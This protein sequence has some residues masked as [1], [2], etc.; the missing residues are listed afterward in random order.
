ME[1]IV[2]E[3]ERN[4][5]ERA[6]NE[7][8]PS[9]ADQTHLGASQSLFEA[10]CGCTAVAL[11]A[12][13]EAQRCLYMN[14]AAERMTGFSYAQV[15]GRSL[16]GSADQTDSES[17]PL[18]FKAGSIKQAL[19]QESPQQGR[20]CFVHQDGHSFPVEYS[21]SPLHTPDCIGML[22][23]VRDLSEERREARDSE[24]RD[25]FFELSLNLLAI[26]SFDGYFIEIN[27]TWK[28]VLGFSPSEL[29]THYYLDFVHPD[30]RAATAAEAQKLVQGRDSVSVQFE[31]RFRTREGAYRWLLWNAVPFEDSRFYAV[32][33]DVTERKLAEAVLRERSAR[34]QFMLNASQ[35]G[36]WEIDLTTP[37]FTAR[38]SL[39]HDQIFGYDAL[40]PDWSYELFI[41]HVHPDDREAVDANFQATLKTYIDWN[42]ECRIV[43]A[44]Q[45]LHWIW[46]RG[47]VYRNPEGIPIRILGMVVDI[48]ERKQAQQLL[49]DSEERYRILTEVAPQAVWTSLLN[50][51]I[52]Y[53]NQYWLDYMG[54]TLKE[55]AGY[56]WI[57]FLHPVDRNR[58]LEIWQRINSNEAQPRPSEYELEVRFRRKGDGEYRWF[59][60]R[61]LPVYSDTGQIKRWIGAA[62]NIHER[63]TAESAKEQLLEQ[64][65]TAREAA[66]RANKIKDE[67][68]AVLSHELRSPLNPILGWS[69]LLQQGDLD[70]ATTA[71]GLE[72]IERNVQLQVQLIDDL[73]DISRIL[74]GKLTLTVVPVE[75]STVISSAF[76]TV[77]LA[78]EAK[79]L[80]VE[81]SL[82]PATINGD[83]TRLQQVVWNLLSNAVKFTPRGGSIK[84]TLAQNATSAVI[85]VIDT[86]KGIEPDFL[87][88]VFEHFRQEDGATTR[89]FGGLGLGLAI[90][91]QIVEMHGGTI[92]AQSAG[93]EKGTTFTVQIPLASQSL[94]SLTA[95]PPAPQATDLSGL[96]ILVVD[97]DTDSREFVA[98]T[99]RQM[100]AG[101]TTAASGA[102]A[103]QVL[104]Q[105][106]PDLLI[107]DI[108]MPEMDGI[109]LMRQIRL[110]PPEQG[111]AI[112]AIALTAYA[113]QQD[114]ELVLEAGFRSHLSKPTNPTAILGRVIQLI[115]P[116]QQRQD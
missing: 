76:E 44:D 11:I 70:A 30:D 69:Q 4:P 72:T 50:G 18:T 79:A 49:R 46:V 63:K 98:L 43:H 21:L 64:E 78:S 65:K 37:N 105:S 107:S 56:G 90:A 87:E 92:L 47:S 29:V 41:E 36:E 103:L 74:R 95:F 94:D 93:A 60:V 15:Q 1:R 40:L 57:Q 16:I 10:V 58:V 51:F 53:I 115:R 116:E 80:E 62:T 38:R 77:R 28:T 75:L 66:E 35:I 109:M 61:G 13:D 26:V 27:P 82:T 33:Q 39:R 100:N 8:F 113:S 9:R 24:Q 88:H 22:I 2:E 67:F 81:L 25:R 112:P 71:I 7:V 111:G 45:S 97:D 114:Q 34:I 17:G 84:V 99:L 12:V 89:K 108:G 110:L 19:L 55:A 23:E 102:E 48:S 52:T 54:L 42:I 20:D 32:A 83:P 106:V 3:L 31:T 68:L 96:K 86:G 6:L 59:M 104:T 14:P 91:R 73:L 101:V 85:Q 5:Q